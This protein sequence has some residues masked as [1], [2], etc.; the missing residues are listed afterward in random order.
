MWFI[1]RQLRGLGHSSMANH[2]G[3]ASLREAKACL[4]HARLGQ[5]LAHV[6]EI[7]LRMQGRSIEQIFGYPDDLK[8]PSC[9]KLF[10]KAASADSCF[11]AALQK[12]LRW[13]AGR[14]D[15]R[16]AEVILG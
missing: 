6:T 1:F 14:A 2:Y 3:I 10:A 4:V 16:S 11:E 13:P 15:H 9:M 5:W 7:V 8:F 12:V